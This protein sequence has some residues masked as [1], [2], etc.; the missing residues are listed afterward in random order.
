MAEFEP[1]AFTIMH[2]SRLSVT[3]TAS[4]VTLP[5][6]NRGVYV[7]DCGRF[8]V[9]ESA[10]LTVANPILLNGTMWKEG[11]GTLALGGAM[12]YEDAEGGISETPVLVDSNKFVVAGGTILAAN[13]DAFRGLETTISNNVT[14]GIR[15]DPNAAGLLRYGAR[16]VAVDNPFKFA[17]SATLALWVDGD[18]HDAPR[19]GTKVGLMT[20]KAAAAPALGE[21]LRDAAKM[22]SWPLMRQVLVEED[23]GDGTVTFSFKV[24]PNGTHI[25]LR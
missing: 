6:A 17:E 3:N 11:D 1:R 23:N 13:V 21:R 2:M 14:F 5:A 10:E 9:D 24:S 4:A 8:Y 7:Y 20:V 18:G 22:R 25:Y 15:Y 12:T 19:G 16:N